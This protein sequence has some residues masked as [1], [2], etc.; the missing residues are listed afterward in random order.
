MRLIKQRQGYLILVS[1]DMGNNCCSAA[2]DVLRHPDV[3]ICYLGL[4]GFTTQLLDSFDDLVKTC[5][6]DWVSARF[7]ST[8]GGNR[9]AP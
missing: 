4:A 5:S 2:T 6:A 3:G 8:A 9:D 1:Q 7:Q